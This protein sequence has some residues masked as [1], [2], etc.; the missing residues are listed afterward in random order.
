VESFSVFFLALGEVFFFEV[1][2]QIGD[3]VGFH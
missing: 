1:S 2:E 3:D